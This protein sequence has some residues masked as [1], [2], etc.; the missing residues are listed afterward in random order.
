MKPI[1]PKAS[2]GYHLNKANSTPPVTAKEAESRWHSFKHNK[3]V[4]E[5]LL[6][7]QYGL[8]CYSELR[9]DREGIGY[10]IEHILLKSL[11]PKQTF[12]YRNLAAS[13]LHDDDLINITKEDRFGGHAPGKQKPY[14]TSLFVSCHDSDCARFFAYL[15]DG[16]VV[17][18]LL[19][20]ESDKN[21]ALYTRDLLNLNSPYL[22]NRR[23]RWHEELAEYYEDH[24][25]KLWRLED[26]AAI[27]LLPTNHRL[28]QFF[29]L[30]RQFFGRVADQVLLLHY[31]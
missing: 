30:T 12:D 6:N 11:Y 4:L 21:R 5:F 23:R 24:Q 28:D 29:S 3:A 15:S 25:N 13:A 7:D 8:C 20:N 10:H 14:D 26:L 19:L 22:V 18:S 1:T 16:R 9:A 2:G 31:P 27:Y 17:P